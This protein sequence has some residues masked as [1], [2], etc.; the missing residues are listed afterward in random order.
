MTLPALI[1]PRATLDIDEQAL[2][3][4]QSSPRV[5]K[6]F[7]DAVKESIDRLDETPDLGS[8]Y[9]PKDRRN[10]LVRVWPTRGF[11]NHLIYYLVGVERIE[12]IR[13][14]HGAR[15]ADAELEQ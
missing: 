9:R 3:L 14:L 7:Q 13:I 11:P 1:K 10:R 2:H 8:V 15:N 5:A 4:A 6:L 12:V